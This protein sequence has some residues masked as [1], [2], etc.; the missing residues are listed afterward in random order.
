MSKKKV[1][2]KTTSK[3]VAKI[4]SELLKNDKNQKIKT[5]A[6]SALSQAEKKKNEK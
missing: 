5:I 3:R 2:N 1:I 6:G 4:A